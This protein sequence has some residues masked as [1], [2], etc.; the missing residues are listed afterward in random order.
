MTAQYQSNGALKV[1]AVAL[2]ASSTLSGCATMGAH[3]RYGP[4]QSKTELSESVFL[5]LTNE[6][7]RTIYVSESRSMSEPVSVVP[8]MRTAL[9]SAGY[10]VVDTPLEA[11]YIVQINHRQLVKHELGDGQGIND[12]IGNA[13]AAGAGAALTADVLGASDIAAELG[14]AVGVVAFLLD[15][16]TQH[17]AHT[18]T[19]DV[20]VTEHRV[21]PAG[22]E[23]REHW[24]QVVAAA[25][26]VNLGHDEA[27]PALVAGVTQALTGLLPVT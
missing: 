19:T 10:S 13:W 3:M 16:N 21:G 1:A 8:A 9:R 12:A 24:T 18:L 7:P 22:S 5:D 11:T 14:L 4:L 2:I 25:S 6:L 27:L 20:L 23:T 17:L 26:K 15:A